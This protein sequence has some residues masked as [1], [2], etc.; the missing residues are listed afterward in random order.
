[1]P[2]FFEERRRAPRVVLK[3]PCEVGLGSTRVVRLVDIS[4]TGALLRSADDNTPVGRR[5]ELRTKLGDHTF[6]VLV[7]IRR[8]APS[9]GQEASTAGCRLG[10]T[11]VSVDAENRRCLERFLRQPVLPQRWGARG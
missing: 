8:V 9:A 6:A 11:F 2:E 4:M 7:E 3:E 10:V 1:M 5:G